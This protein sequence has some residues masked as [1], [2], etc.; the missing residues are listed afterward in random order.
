MSVTWL[1][2]VTVTGAKKPYL[3][4][5]AYSGPSGIQPRLDA[6]GT[7]IATAGDSVTFNVINQTQGNPGNCDLIYIA[8]T[9]ANPGKKPE[10]G[11][12]FSGQL[13]HYMEQGKGAA[14]TLKIA[15]TRGQIVT[16]RFSLVVLLPG[17]DGSL[18]GVAALDDPS[19]IVNPGI[20]PGPG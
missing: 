4:S 12:A 11:T 14:W 17:K 16:G 8:M 3:A 5:I 1:A 6:N 2:E 20:N 15:E 13:L 19:V 9:T 18:D 7:L 10:R